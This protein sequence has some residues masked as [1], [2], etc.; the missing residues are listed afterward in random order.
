[1]LFL[2]L[3]HF[4]GSVFMAGTPDRD[5]CGTPEDRQRGTNNKQKTLKELPM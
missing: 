4:L 5:A 3:N 1:M 2:I